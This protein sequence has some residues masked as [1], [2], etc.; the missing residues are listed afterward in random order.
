MKITVSEIPEEGFEVDLKENIKF[1][2]LSSKPVTVSAH[3]EAKRSGRDVFINGEIQA[4]IEMTCVRCLNPVTESLDL[5]FSV[6]YQPSVELKGD[7]ELHKGDLESS[8]Y[9]NDEIDLREILIEQIIIHCPINP[10]CDEGCKGLCS[11]CG[12]NLNNGTC[13]CDK[14]I[15]DSRWNKLKNI[16][17]ERKE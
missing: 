15:T 1:D 6:V 11:K 16:T 17:F 13:S 8:F 3:V 14:D 7:L 2:D 10:L 9:D 12:V 4:S 5:D